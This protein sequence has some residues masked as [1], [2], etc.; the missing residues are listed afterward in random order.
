MIE[1][2]DDR[3]SF[4]QAINDKVA[5]L[6]PKFLA[7]T[8]VVNIA[9]G[10]NTGE[11]AVMYFAVILSSTQDPSVQQQIAVARATGVPR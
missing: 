9:P 3:H 2:W 1:V 5:E 11:F 7:C 6:G 8:P 10:A 4:E